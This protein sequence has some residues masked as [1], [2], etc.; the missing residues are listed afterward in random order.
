MMGQFSVLQFEEFLLLWVLG[1]GVVFDEFDKFVFLVS[2]RIGY[3]WCP[4]AP[5]II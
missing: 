4:C 5:D 1:D 2:D 3:A